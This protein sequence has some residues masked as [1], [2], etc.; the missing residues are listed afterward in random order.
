MRGNNGELTIHEGQLAMHR[1]LTKGELTT[2][3]RAR[4]FAPFLEVFP[5]SVVVRAESR[6]RSAPPHRAVA[7]WLTGPP[8]VPTQLHLLRDRWSDAGSMTAIECPRCETT[9]ETQ[10]T[11]ATRCRSCRSVVHVGGRGTGQRSPAL[12]P[13]TTAWSAEPADD[14]DGRL[15]VVGLLVA[16][17]V[18]VG[19]YLYVKARRSRK[20]AE[21]HEDPSRSDPPD[22]P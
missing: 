19:I 12:R 16:V 4:A 13:T 8:P 17:A 21:E 2:D 5:R 15:V 3:G 20:A 6:C 7:C 11:T 18:G 1:H 14:R 22:I 10:A 9:F